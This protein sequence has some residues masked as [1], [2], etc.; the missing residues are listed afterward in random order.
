[1]DKKQKIQLSVFCIII[2]VFFMI[3][4]MYAGTRV[5]SDLGEFIYN[6]KWIF[7]KSG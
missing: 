7:G 5:G 6:I 1:M 3:F 2:L 4:A